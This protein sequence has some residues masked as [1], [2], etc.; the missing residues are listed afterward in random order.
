M[1]MVFDGENDIQPVS[2]PRY[3]TDLLDASVISVTIATAF[4]AV[5]QA[6]MKFA[7]SITDRSIQQPQLF[8]SII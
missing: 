7:T 5:T 4:I 6:V 2:P 1:L 8:I 3:C